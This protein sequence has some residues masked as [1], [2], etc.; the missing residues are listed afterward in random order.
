[1]LMCR[2]LKQYKKVKGEKQKLLPLLVQLPK[3]ITINTLQILLINDFTVIYP[4]LT[5]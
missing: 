4:S 3:V 5:T 2:K 1:M